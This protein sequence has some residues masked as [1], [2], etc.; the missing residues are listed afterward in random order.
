MPQMLPE[1]E[2]ATPSAARVPLVWVLPRHHRD[3]SLFT[4]SSLC[5]PFRW[6]QGPILSWD[7]LRRLAV[8]AYGHYLEHAS[9]ATVTVAN[10]TEHSDREGLIPVPCVE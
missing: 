5:P 8:A 9:L 1:V 10:A 3:L 2:G 4:G 7:V 6:G